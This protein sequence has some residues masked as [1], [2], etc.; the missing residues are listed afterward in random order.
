MPR[1]RV[2]ALNLET[3]RTYLAG[4]EA[5]VQEARRSDDPRVLVCALTVV[6]RQGKTVRE[7]TSGGLR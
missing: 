4:L 1:V 7:L 5:L 6:A 3:A 2:K